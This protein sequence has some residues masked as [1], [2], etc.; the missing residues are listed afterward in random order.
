M[1]C[2]HLYSAI[3]LIF[4]HLT[5]QCCARARTPSSHAL[6]LAGLVFIFNCALHAAK[7]RSSPRRHLRVA[8]ALLS[9]SHTPLSSLRDLPPSCNPCE[10]WPSFLLT[11]PAPLGRRRRCGLLDRPDDVELCA[12]E[13]KDV[14]TWLQCAQAALHAL[15]DIAFT[16]ASH[17][18][19]VS[20][21]ASNRAALMRCFLLLLQQY[22]LGDASAASSAPSLDLRVRVA[23]FILRTLPVYPCVLDDLY[24]NHRVV[25]FCG[26]SPWEL[27]L[28][29][30]AAIIAE[31][32]GCSAQ[33]VGS[34]MY[35]HGT[36][37]SRLHS[38]M[39]CNVR[40]GLSNSK[41]MLWGAQHG[42]GLYFTPHL[43]VA[44]SFSG[45]G[46]GPVLLLQAAGQLRHCATDHNGTCSSMLHLQVCVYSAN[47]Y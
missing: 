38:I 27:Q 34:G 11:S 21:S 16:I 41:L 5:L 3:Q 17:A 43:S 25:W 32:E 40:S 42:P 6:Q 9:L 37:W 15:Q 1:T 33:D 22:E 8:L 23:A 14:S 7:E 39:R 28:Q 2:K 13:G 10:P 29:R 44:E 31:A 26:S 18:C 47:T 46:R 45:G 36:R 35:F 20:P 30:D 19:S 24:S 4:C 12:A